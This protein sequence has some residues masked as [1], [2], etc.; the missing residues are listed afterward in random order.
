MIDQFI[1]GFN[2]G[3]FLWE[4]VKKNR[5]VFQKL[6]TK[7]KPLSREE[8]KALYYVKWSNVDSAKRAEEEETMFLFESNLV[9][10]AGRFLF[11]CLNI[12]GKVDKTLRPLCFQKVKRPSLLKTF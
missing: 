11:I 4:T 2:S 9:T 7:R 6:S 8:F 10:I 5:R 3:G 12:N 1:E